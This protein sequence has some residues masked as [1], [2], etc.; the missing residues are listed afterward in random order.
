MDVLQ[1]IVQVADAVGR[2]SGTPSAELAGTIVG[3]LACHP[4]DVDRFL[5][6]G[7]ELF[8][9]GT[10]AYETSGLSY[11]CGDGE[12]RHGADFRARRQENH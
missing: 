11:L 5:R 2:Q 4:E 12:I 8:I 3:H 6:E 1:K 7:S 9:D 10:I